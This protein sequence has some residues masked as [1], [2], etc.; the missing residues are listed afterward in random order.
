M[1]A[2]NVAAELWVCHLGTRSLSRGPRH[3]G[4]GPRAAPGRRAARHAA[5]ARAPARV[6]ARPALAAPRTCRSAR[7]STAPEGIDVVDTD[8]GGQLTYHGPGQL[9]GYPIM[10][11]RG[12]AAHLRTMEAAIIAALAEEGLRAR[13]RRDEGIDYTGVWV[14][15]PQDRLHRR[16]RRPRRHHP[17]LRRQRRQRP[18][19][20]LL[21]DRLR[22]ARRAA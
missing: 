5:A 20:V 16:A 17:R 6:H 15:G 10:A 14:R 21:G 11:R 19:A 2:P 13:S 8:R 7:T 18:R 9:V 12:R 4:A 22:A 3:P 1:T